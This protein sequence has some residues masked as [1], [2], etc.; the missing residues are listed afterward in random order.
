MNDTMMTIV[1]APKSHRLCLWNIV[2]SF[3]IIMEL[4]LSF[5]FIADS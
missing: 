4:H 1:N 3:L 5:V 2:L